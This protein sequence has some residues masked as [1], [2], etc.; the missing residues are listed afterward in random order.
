MERIDPALS[1]V[2]GLR[3]IPPEI[4][5]SEQIYYKF[6]NGTQWTMFWLGIVSF[7]ASLLVTSFSKEL[8]YVIPFWSLTITWL[9]LCAFVAAFCT[10]IIGLLSLQAKN[11]DVWTAWRMLNAGMLRYKYDDKFTLHELLEVY[12]SAEATIGNVILS[13]K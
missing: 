3:P 6:A 12:K 4:L 2:S 7:G 9:K 13:M 8:D 11:K 1:E 5:K 10:G